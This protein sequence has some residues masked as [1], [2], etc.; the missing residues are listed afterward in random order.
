[1]I[2]S[3]I[4]FFK[5]FN[6]TYGHLTGDMVL[7]ESASFFKK[8]IRETD[9]AARY[10]GEEFA[11]ILPDTELQDAIS[12][13]RRLRY[14]IEAHDFQG[15]DCPLHVTIS[16][17]VAEYLPDMDATESDLIK[18]ADM[19]LYKAKELGRNRIVAHSGSHRMMETI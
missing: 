2:M 8:T 13:A 10:G 6:D 1:V 15:P 4:D 18:R 12:I 11:I 14:G 16:L 9:I 5:K 3:D 7:R 19:A 17:G